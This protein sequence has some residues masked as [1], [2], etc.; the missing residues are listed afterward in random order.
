MKVCFAVTECVPYVKT[1]GLA[2]VGGALPKAL[3]RSGCEVKVF[4]PLY[5]SI[6]P[7]DHKLTL[8]EEL[9]NMTASVGV[10]PHT[11]H[12]W[13]GQ[14]PDSEVDVYF[15]DCPEYFHRPHPY[16]TDPDEDERFIL[17][18]QAIVHVLQHLHW[19]PD[20]LHCNDWQTG[21][22]PAFLKL[23]YHWDRL[24]DGTATLFSI[25]NVG[26]Q[27]RFAAAT[28][29]K[30]GLPYDHYYP[31]GPFE[32]DG[33]F[34]FLKIGILFSDVITTVSETYAQEI[35]TPVYG[36]GMEGV[37][38][39]RKDDISGIL[40][41]IDNKIW[42]PEKD[43]FI[44][45]K[46]S[47][48]NLGNKKKNKQALLADTHLPFDEKT[49]TIGI[50]SR[51]T[52]QKG[53]EL[54]QPIL[55][56]MM[57]HSVQFVALGSGERDLEDFF[58]WTAA[59]YEDKFSVYIGYNDK[60]AHQI[61]AGCDMFL[62]PSLYEPCG[63]NQM[64]SLNYGTVPIV[65]RT[66]GLVDTVKD[67]HEYYKKGNGFSFTEYRPEV[68]YLTIVRALDMFKQKR[69]WRD[70]MKRGMQQDFSWEHS[71]KQYV[72]LYKKAKMKRASL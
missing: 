63:L 24:F 25:H 16:T 30:A 64:Y 50:V 39:S 42:N 9:K 56:E 57:E 36:E 66:G 5:G 44:P 6:S 62:M 10:T 49:P 48:K 15:I 37:I 45:Y 38:A 22:L 18:Q 68:L 60:L 20:V 61:T 59:N 33:S 21:L 27:G 53:F 51:L 52:K 3:A 12:V 26:Y 29:G 70:L 14:L 54:L 28:V 4:L 2:D 17:F 46:Y 72:D 7:L 34:C 40:N 19:A 31:G 58:R 71:A 43:E 35:Q 32:L 1:G 11:F 69:V 8:T 65:R 67:Y 41:G 55:H 23:S 47:I 13:Q